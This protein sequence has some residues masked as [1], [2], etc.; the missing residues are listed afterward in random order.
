MKVLF[1]H[2]GPFSLAHGGL[3]I[4]ILRTFEA[5]QQQGVNIEFL[6]WYDPAQTGDL[7]HFFGRMPTSMLDM[8]H[9]KAM[10]V[11]VSDLLTAQGSRSAAQLKLQRM[12]TRLLRKTFPGLTRGIFNWQ[13]YSLADACVALTAWEAHLMHYLFAAPKE[14]MHV[15]PNGVEAVFLDAATSVRGQWLVC[16]ATITERKRVLELA[17]AAVLARTPLWVVGK[18]YAESEHYFQQFLQLTRRHSELIRYEGA[19]EDRGRLAEVYRQARGFVLLSTVESLSLS[20]LEA[21]ACEC[22]LLLSDLPWSKTTF[23]QNVSYCP[24]TLQTQKTAQALRDFYA[25]APSFKPPPKPD[26]WNTVAV[27]LHSIYQRVLS[28]SP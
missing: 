27:Q 23:G 16:T 19:I 13:T 14:K 10:K 1:H 25:A 15:V 3:Q 22:P 11:V 7:L 9:D 24:V 12:V 4:Q 26:N 6:R 20:A 5:L 28:T 2:L 17:Q 21:A 8:A 18:P